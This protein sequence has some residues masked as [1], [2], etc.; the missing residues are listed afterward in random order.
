MNDKERQCSSGENVKT[1]VLV[2]NGED[3]GDEKSISRTRVELSALAVYCSRLQARITSLENRLSVLVNRVHELEIEE[4]E[5]ID[6]GDVLD[7][8]ELYKNDNLSEKEKVLDNLAW[9]VFD[10]DSCLKRAGGHYV[11][12][13]LIEDILSCNEDISKNDL[14]IGLEDIVSCALRWCNSRSRWWLNTK[15]WVQPVK[16]YLIIKRNRFAFQVRELPDDALI[17]K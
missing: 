7:Y 17:I 13:N 2:P 16:E 3:D 1:D 6:A 8:V 15:C 14:D 10:N 11:L 12:Q 4:V 5:V 9:K